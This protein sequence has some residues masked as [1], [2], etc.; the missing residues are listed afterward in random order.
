MSF[1]LL[2]KNLKINPFTVI[3]SDF[4]TRQ[5]NQS[6]MSELF[7]DFKGFTK[8][9]TLPDPFNSSHSEDLKQPFAEVYHISHLQSAEFLLRTKTIIPQLIKDKSKLNKERIQ[10]IW[11][12]PNEWAPGSLYGNVRFTFEFNDI[13][14]DKRFYAVEVMKEYTPTV[15]RILITQKDYSDN[16]LLQE[17]HPE[18]PNN[19][20]WHRDS[21]NSNYFR[22]ECN[23]EFMLEDELTI[24]H[25]KRI[26]FV[27]HHR[28]ICNIYKKG[29]CPSLSLS[30]SD[31]EML[32]VSH[33]I[34]NQTKLPNLAL[35][36]SKHQEHQSL[37]P[38]SMLFSKVANLID[39]EIFEGSPSLSKRTKTQIALAFLG[40]IGEGKVAEANEII[41]A[42]PSKDE[43][44]RTIKDIFLDYF[45]ISDL[46][47]VK[48]ILE[49]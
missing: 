7:R 29:T 41:A 30:N 47:S 17:F 21:D 25:A 1:I 37:L 44:V 26:D 28:S 43:A 34:S 42:L 32:F 24:E 5:L 19:G 22:K 20:V 15:L 9:Y 13:I 27:S 14:K 10:V 38:I 23:I 45:E 31:A 36:E 35:H 18:D 12:S 6:K 11:L 3:N 39:R 48:D 4:C 49:I 46:P 33:L 2:K 40:L 8:S 16:K